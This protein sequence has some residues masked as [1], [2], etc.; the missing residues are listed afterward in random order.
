MLAKSA[1][2]HASPSTN[3]L[4]QMCLE[5]VNQCGGGF[6]ASEWKGDAS[7]RDVTSTSLRACCFTLARSQ[8]SAPTSALLFTP[9]S[10]KN[11]VL[12]YAYRLYGQRSPIT[13]RQIHPS[14]PHTPPDK[15]KAVG[16]IE[17]KLR[18]SGASLEEYEVPAEEDAA[19]DGKALTKYVEAVS[20]STF[21]VRIVLP[22]CATLRPDDGVAC[23]VYLDGEFVTGRSCYSSQ[24][25]SAPFILLI[26]GI[27]SM[28]PRGRELQRFTFAQLKTIDGPLTANTKP[29]HFKDI[30]TIMIECTWCRQV[31][32]RYADFKE[33]PKT[34]I[35]KSIPEKCLKGRAISNQAG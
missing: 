31:P 10:T 29:E 35:G 5:T 24:Y 14:H 11:S 12:Y 18:V 16:G 25:R 30:G 7:R 21:A 2:R 20:G 32:T 27:D 28:T 13:T 3:L 19:E 4:E 8:P 17:V 9:L 15:M 34:A 23:N 6:C 33:V 1:V 26:E 22:A